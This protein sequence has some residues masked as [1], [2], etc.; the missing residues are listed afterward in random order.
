MESASEFFYA[1]Q[2]VLKYKVQWKVTKQVQDSP[3][4]TL[5]GLHSEFAND[6][7]TE[8]DCDQTTGFIY[9]HT[10]FTRSGGIKYEVRQSSPIITNI[11]I[12][13]GLF[14]CHLTYTKDGKEIHIARVY[15]LENID[16]D[17]EV[18]NEDFAIEVPKETML[19]KAD[20]E[21]V[22]GRRPHVKTSSPIADLR[23]VDF[24]KLSTDNKIKMTPIANQPKSKSGISKIIF[25][26]VANGIVL[27]LFA[28]WY[29]VKNSKDN[30]KEN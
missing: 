18:K 11:G 15:L 25:L 3:R 8:I 10:V 26:I 14:H 13:V 5:T 28:A 22:D 30:S 19:V 7:V 6:I 17:S 9:R 20:G 16:F 23:K 29:F 4:I 1:P 21:I 12:P 2:R 27:M 24:K